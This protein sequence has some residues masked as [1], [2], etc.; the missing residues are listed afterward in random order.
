MANPYFNAAYYLANN[1][2]VFAAGVDA[3][4]H[5]RD[6]GASEAYVNGA[7][8]RTPAPW[9]DIQ[10]Y[11]NNNPDVAAAVIGN[12]AGAFDHFTT[13]GIAEGRAPSANYQ[14]NAAKLGAYAAANSDLMDAF[15]IT[16]P[17][18]LTAEQQTQLA[19]HYY[20]YGWD[21]GRPGDPGF[22]GEH[23]LTVDPDNVQMSDLGGVVDAPLGR[24]KATGLISQETLNSDDVIQGG[25]GHDVLNAQL[26]GIDT[27]GGTLE[28]T[29]NGVEEYNFTVARETWEGELSLHRASGYESINNVGSRGDLDIWDVSAEGGAPVLG[30]S[31][32]RGHTYITYN[33]DTDQIETQNVTADKVGRV[34]DVVRLDVDNEDGNLDIETLNLSV[35]RGVYLNLAYAA[36]RI[37]NLNVQGTDAAELHNRFDFANLVNLDGG[38]HDGGLTI[39]VSGSTVLESVITGAGD[40]DVTV[41]RAA[42]VEGFSAA[43]GDGEDTLAIRHVH[44]HNHVNGLDF[45]A[46]VSG[47]EHLAFTGWL[48]LGGDATLDLSGVNNDLQS[49]DFYRDFNGG[50]SNVLTIASSPVEDLTINGQRDINGLRLDA[51][52]LVNLD[53]NILGEHLDLELYDLNAGKLES[54]ELNQLTGKWGYI[55]AELTSDA[56]HDLSSLETVEVS[57]DGDAYIWFNGMAAESDFDAL[58]EIGVHANQRDA[59]LDI[60]GN[61][62]GL[63]ADVNAA[64]AAVVTAV[65]A[66]DADAAALAT[67]TTALATAE[68]AR[69]AAVTDLA[70]AEAAFNAA[71]AALTDAQDLIALADW[72]VPTFNGWGG[73]SE[74]RGN[75]NHNNYANYINSIN[76]WPTGLKQALIDALPSGTSFDSFSE[77]NAWRDAGGSAEAVFNSYFDM[78]T[79]IANEAAADTW[80]NDPVT[81]AIAVEAAAQIA[82]SS[83]HTTW[84]NADAAAD[85]SQAA[86]DQA[87]V[88]LADAQQALADA[89]GGYISLETVLVDSTEGDAD[90]HIYDAHGNFTLNVSA[91]VDADV[92]LYNTGAV[93]VNVEAGEEA[94]VDIDNGNDALTNVTIAADEAKVYLWDSLASFETLDLTGVITK[95]DVDAEH[96]EYASGAIV[97]YLIGG[98]DGEF[99]AE[100]GAGGATHGV[101]REIFK[102]SAEFGIGESVVIENFWMG[103]TLSEGNRDIIDLRD[104][105]FDVSD[106]SVTSNP[107]GD[108]FI[109]DLGGNWEIELAG[110]LTG[111]H[112]T[113]DFIVANLLL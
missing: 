14:L 110:A 1:A 59:H 112:D 50:T 60:D 24:D 26:N 28:P 63:R 106:L 19:Q 67:A 62:S 89:A 104:F 22:G 5:Y 107:L 35:S 87:W 6:F 17:N 53:I 9:F 84:V 64:Q 79:L 41:H 32:V 52:D 92:E 46:G 100:Y 97:T 45:S 72:T 65:T 43:M 36:G 20:Q 13:H 15:G 55:N 29:I 105:G 71:S 12:V 57:A 73:S 76:E 75:Q 90:A 39:D 86:L 70:N 103:D 66:R 93:E 48:N 42:V 80:L 74:A 85:A 68:T 51:A 111:A 34:D 108:V 30:L 27:L 61:L 31:D 78:A 3:E 99:E 88:D 81:G 7:A 56:D 2:D 11:L 95:F 54:L 18:N 8:S 44:N 37:E 49:L 23:T 113:T 77:R 109:S 21:E 69:D 38:N 83:A 94:Y 33:D 102:F 4:T 96:A 91:A 16:D 40:D 10:Y 47:V 58:R 101:T 98:S 25:A 82:Y